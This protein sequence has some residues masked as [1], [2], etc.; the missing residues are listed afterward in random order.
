MLSPYATHHVLKHFNSI[1]EAVAAKL[2]Y[3]RPRDE[4][5]LTKSLIDALDEECQEQENISYT[6]GELKDDLAKNGE[7]T[8]VDLEIETHAYSK[9]WERY[10]S[11]SDLGLIVRYK[12]YYEP[13]LSRSWA[14]LLQAKRLFPVKG[15]N[16]QYSSDCRFES[17]D[18]QQ[19]ERIKRLQ[20]F[21]D[22]DFFRYLFYCPRPERLEDTVRQELAYLR[23]ASLRDEIFDFTYGLELRDDLRNGSRTAAAGIFVSKVEPCPKNFADVHS[24]IFNGTTPLSWFILEHIPGRGW[25]H[26]LED[27]H[28]HSNL[29]NDIA[30]KLV[31]GD[32]AVIHEVMTR[33]EDKEMDLKILPS[34][35]ITVT[36]SQGTENVRRLDR[37]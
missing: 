34:A 8:Y 29:N 32:A 24:R 37:P 25:H 18:K 28:W 12:N 5:D 22:A 3:K 27:E 7:P 36:I 31:R 4:E 30:E 9:Q 11:Q 19:H 6:I 17:F 33:L 15:T 14:W 21:L 2:L 10:V 13:I 20:E 26:P 23:T 35:T 16:N 1:D